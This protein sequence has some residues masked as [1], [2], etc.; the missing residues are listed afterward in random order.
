MILF[1][2]IVNFD[3][4]YF[5]WVLF[6]VCL[7]KLCMGSLIKRYELNVNGFFS[8]ILLGFYRGKSISS[9]YIGVKKC[10]FWVCVI[11]IDGGGFNFNVEVV[12]FVRR[13]VKSIFLS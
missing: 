13:G 7:C 5:F 12:N 6:L 4:F 9:R 8:L 11:F 3:L 10:V 1:F 2:F